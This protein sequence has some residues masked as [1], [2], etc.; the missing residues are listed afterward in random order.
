MVSTGRLGTAE[1]GAPVRWAPWDEEVARLY[2]SG[3]TIRRQQ[4]RVDV[5]GALG[6]DGEEGVREDVAVGGGDA[7]VRLQRL[8]A[9]RGSTLRACRV[10]G[11]PAADLAGC[12]ADLEG[13]KAD[14]A[15]CEADRVGSASLSWKRAEQEARR[16]RCVVLRS[17]VECCG[18]LWQI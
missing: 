2:G 13:C 16:C 7:D 17:A 4:R 3:A 6:R 12:E 18:V 9:R 8:G 1:S 5:E 14:L 11:P 10:A 15:G